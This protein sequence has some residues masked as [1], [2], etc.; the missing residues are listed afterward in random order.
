MRLWPPASSSLSGSSGE[1]QS[2]PKRRQMPSSADAHRLLA[3]AYRKA[4]RDA[5]AAREEADAVK[6]KVSPEPPVEPAL[7]PFG[8]WGEN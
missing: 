7:H 3:E 1:R 6:S 8:I 5:D 2:K 4:G